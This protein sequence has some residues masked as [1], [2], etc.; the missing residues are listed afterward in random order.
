MR[1]GTKLPGAIRFFSQ[2][3]LALNGRAPR[4]VANYCTLAQC[5]AAAY[6]G[7][8]KKASFFIER[9][10]WCLTGMSPVVS[11]AK[12]PS[13]VTPAHAQVTR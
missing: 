6:A 13:P 3:M 11:F 10:L 9:L 7:G 4:V 5:Q 1:V 2:P 12:A 8:A